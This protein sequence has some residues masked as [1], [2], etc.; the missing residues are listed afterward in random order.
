MANVK[1]KVGKDRKFSIMKRMRKKLSFRTCCK[2]VSSVSPTQSVKSED[3]LKDEESSRHQDSQRSE[4]ISIQQSHDDPV[5]TI[6]QNAGVLGATTT[7][8]SL[9]PATVQAI[10]VPC[11]MSR[12]SHKGVTDVKIVVNKGAKDVNVNINSA[13]SREDLD[14]R[15]TD[16]KPSNL[17]KKKPPKD[18]G[19]DDG[20]LLNDVSNVALPTDGIVAARAVEAAAVKPCGVHVDRR[21]RDVSLK[22]LVEVSPTLEELLEDGWLE[23]GMSVKYK[24]ASSNMGLAGET[25]YGGIL[26]FCRNCDGRKDVQLTVQLITYI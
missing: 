21:H 16:S 15:Y 25:A 22:N 3:E 18:V 23:K 5:P 2:K 19:V 4:S 8:A 6:V 20:M 13:V 12:N 24:N 17:L 26:C 11:S 7:S 14:K 1:N 9:L 10:G